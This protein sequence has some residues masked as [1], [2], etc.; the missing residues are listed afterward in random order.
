MSCVAGAL[1]T[2]GHDGLSTVPWQRGGAAALDNDPVPV[3]GCTLGEGVPMMISLLALT[4]NGMAVGM[5]LQIIISGEGF[6][7]NWVG[8][9]A[10]GAVSVLLIMGM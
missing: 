5:N 1:S 8:M 6:W 10:C 7:G 3:P 9:V 4:I 2:G